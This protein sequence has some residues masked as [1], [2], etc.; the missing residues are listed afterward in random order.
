MISKST[1]ERNS[2][3]KV[4]SL[5]TEEGSL[6]TFEKMVLMWDPHKMGKE[7]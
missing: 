3:C 5:E 6:L 2:S 1:Y 4:I 7:T